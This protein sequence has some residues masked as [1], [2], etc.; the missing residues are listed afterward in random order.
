M[1][2]GSPKSAKTT[3]K[4]TTRKTRTRYRNVE[5]D[6]ETYRIAVIGKGKDVPEAEK[7]AIAGLVCLMYATDLYSL[8]ECLAACGI[9]SDSTWYKWLDE[10]GEIEPLYLEAQ[11]QKDRRYRHKM[12]Q[13]ARTM[14]E[15]LLEGYSF[16]LTEREAEPTQDSEGNTTLI[17]TKV[18]RKEVI[19]RPSVRLIETFLFN[20]DGRNFTRNPEPYKAGNE[21]LPT[22]IDINIK[23]G[24]VPPVTSEEDI[25]QD[26]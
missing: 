20:L 10:I 25:N 17:T 21:Q 16:E 15:R 5:F 19:V 14:A 26:V 23:G 2:K 6:D 1:A 22:K 11:R 8:D 24:S 12:K 7:I 18:K 13:R 4:K 9:T 3:T